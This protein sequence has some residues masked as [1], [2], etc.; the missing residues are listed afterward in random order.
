MPPEIGAVKGMEESLRLQDATA[1]KMKTLRHLHGA[2]VLET[3]EAKPVFSGDT[4]MGLEA[5]TRNR[6]KEFIEDFMIAANG[7]TARYLASKTFPSVRRMVRTPKRWE[8]IVAIAA[9]RGTA[10][11][12]Q[13]DAKALED[14]L[15]A[16]KKADPLRFP[17]L[18]LT[19]I[20]LLGSGE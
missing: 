8:R 15:P 20:K 13:P 4:L 14:F 10:L 7:V 19:I 11:P 17:D 2:L 16:S 12:A 18:S 1:Q 3:I 9:E 5:D 6:A